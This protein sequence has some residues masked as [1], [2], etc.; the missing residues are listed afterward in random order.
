MW[1]TS[2]MSCLVRCRLAVV[3]VALLARSACVFSCCARCSGLALPSSALRS[4]TAA[5]AT[6]LCTYDEARHHL[7]GHKARHH[8]VHHEYTS[9]WGQRWKFPRISHLQ[10]RFSEVLL[11]VLVL[12][13][14]SVDH[15]HN[16]LPFLHP[17]AYI[18][19]F[20]T[21]DAPTT[22]SQGR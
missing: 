1:G 20:K 3:S 8:S 18:T 10:A 19:D 7:S 13:L 12:P 9:S 21:L 15:S 17:A 16:C 22:A 11:E 14:V 4:S 6:L 2:A 5:R